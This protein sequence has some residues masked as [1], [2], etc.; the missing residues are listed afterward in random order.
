MTSHV[1]VMV[2]S[3]PLISLKCTILYTVAKVCQVVSDELKK[4]AMDLC[5]YHYLLLLLLVLLLGSKHRSA[6]RYN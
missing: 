4:S 5:Y 3:C 1:F 6:S 2:L